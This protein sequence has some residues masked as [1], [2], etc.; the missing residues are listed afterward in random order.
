MKGPF[1]EDK[2]RTYTQQLYTKKKSRMVTLREQI[3]LLML[4]DAL[5]LQ[6]L[7][8][9]NRVH[10]SGWLLN[11]FSR[12]ICIIADLL[13]SLIYGVWGA[14]LLRWP[15]E[16]LGGEITTRR[17]L[18]FQTYGEIRFCS[19]NPRQSFFLWETVFETMSA[20]GTKFE[21]ICIP[22]A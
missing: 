16:I 6:I 15:L 17:G 4:M 14:L 1:D 13:I 2:I 3:S 19:S 11:S 21:G 20:K 22:V 9:L 18:F 5:N 8:Y 12:R 10:N 7:V